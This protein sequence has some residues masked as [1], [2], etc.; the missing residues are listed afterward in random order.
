[1][2]KIRRYMKYCDESQRSRVCR[3]RLYER[4][5]SLWFVGFGLVKLQKFIS[6]RRCLRD[7]ALRVNPEQHPLCALGSACSREQMR[8]CAA[9]T[10][11]AAGGERGHTVITASGGRNG[12]GVLRLCLRHTASASSGT[13]SGRQ[14]I[15]WQ[16][17]KSQ[18]EGRRLCGRTKRRD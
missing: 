9:Q 1:M 10:A 5:H 14:V 13:S 3:A 6:R 12:P 17:E 7:D 15:H 2:V 16:R 18:S 4:F 11:S 8:L